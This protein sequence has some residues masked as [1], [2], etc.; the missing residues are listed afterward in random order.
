MSTS[1]SSEFDYVV[2]DSESSLYLKNHINVN[3]SRLGSPLQNVDLRVMD[4]ST[5]VYSTAYF[6][7]SD[8][9]T[10]YTGS[11]ASDILVIYRVYDGSSTATDN[12]TSVKI[13]IGDWFK[14]SKDII[15]DYTVFDFNVPHFRVT[16]TNTGTKYAYVQTAIDNAT[17]G[18]TIVLEAGIYRENIVIDKGLNLRGSAVDDGNNIEWDGVHTSTG[19]IFTVD[20]S[21][22]LGAPPVA[23]SSRAGITVAANDVSINSLMLFY[24]ILQV[25]YLL[26]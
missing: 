15:E 17:A 25:Y 26:F 8:S 20:N 19:T 4:G 22:G 1:I 9:K 21:D 6:G 12:E 11:L 10:A 2:C 18:H 3:I 5:T 7:G 24:V 16:N 23:N 13:R 14:S